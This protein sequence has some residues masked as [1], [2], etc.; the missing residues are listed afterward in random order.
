MASDVREESARL[1]GRFQTVARRETARMILWVKRR[2][3][4]HMG[5]FFCYGLY[6]F[7]V[8]DYTY[9]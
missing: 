3:R 2:R 1:R 9:V 5:N 6:N 8:Y 4:R 7:Q